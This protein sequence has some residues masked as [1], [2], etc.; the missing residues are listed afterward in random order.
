MFSQLWAAGLRGPPAKY[1]VRDGDVAPCLL[2]TPLRTLI[3]RL[4]TT[5]RF[6]YTVMPT[7]SWCT[8][9]LIFSV[10]RLVAGMLRYTSKAL[11]WPGMSRMRTPT[12]AL[13]VFWMARYT[14][15]F[16]P[17]LPVAKYQVVD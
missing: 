11:W 4:A 1:Q 7:E 15:Y 2:L 10:L 3:V 16:P 12:A 6:A 5:G 17:V 13:L 8:K 9:L 14:R